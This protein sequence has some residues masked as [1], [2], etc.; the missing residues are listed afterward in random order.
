MTEGPDQAAGPHPAGVGGAQPALGPTLAALLEVDFSVQLRNYRS[1]MLSLVLPVVLLF[2]LSAGK[3]AAA[4]GDPRVRI[5]L[6]MIL[7]MATIAEGIETERQLE[8]LR[9]LGCPLGQGFLLSRPLDQA[10]MLALVAG[11]SSLSGRRIAA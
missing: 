10:A 6:V 11:S 3:R 8:R 5:S 7:G 4:L 1:L 9:A 2:A